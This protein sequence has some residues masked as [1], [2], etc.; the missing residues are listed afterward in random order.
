MKNLIGI[1]V[2]LALS[3]IGWQMFSSADSDSNVEITVIEQIKKV[4]KLQTIEMKVATTLTKTKT[5]KVGKV[6]KKT[7][8]RTASYFAEGTVSASINLEDMGI[9]LDKESNLVTI[10][11]P[12]DVEVSNPTHDNFVNTC[13]YVKGVFVPKFSAEDR[14]NHS[15]EA[16]NSM[17]QKALDAGIKGKAIEQAKAYLTVFVNALGRDIQFK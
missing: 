2:L 5:G 7:G 15:N 16:F 17:K 14:A 8:T 3:F 10:T 4:A 6:I 13:S 12:T 9:E 1:G 11:L